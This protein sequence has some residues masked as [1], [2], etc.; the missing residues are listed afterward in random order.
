MSISAGG[1]S[2]SFPKS[3]KLFAMRSSRSDSISMTSTSSCSCAGAWPR[4][5]ASANRIGVRGFLI[6][7]ATRRAVSLNAWSLSASIAC[8]R[9]CASSDTISRMLRL[10][11]SNSG[12]PRTLLVVTSIVPPPSPFF[13]VV[14]TTF[15]SGGGG[16]D[17]PCPISSVQRTSSSSG[18]LNWRLRCPATRDAAP[19]ST[20]R[21]RTPA[22]AMTR[23][24]RAARKL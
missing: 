19:V 23:T 12:A 18:R 11:V 5:R 8:C 16:S 9:P 2:G 4:S 17:S 6:S 14:E 15:G 24:V 1:P 13:C 7:C 20:S 3:A 21:A 22:I 10:S